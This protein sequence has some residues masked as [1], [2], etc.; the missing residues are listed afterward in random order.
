MQNRNKQ[1]QF[2]SIEQLYYFRGRINQQQREWVHKQVSKRNISQSEYLRN[3][4]DKDIIGGDN[5]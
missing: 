5:D 4:I 1:G 3:L 2:E